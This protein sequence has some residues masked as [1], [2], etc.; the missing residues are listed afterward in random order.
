MPA[1]TP[2][3]EA[4]L[5]GL[6]GRGA[7][8][9]Q[10]TRE[11]FETLLG[12]PLGDVRLHSDARAGAL[13]ASLNANALAYGRD[14][15]FAPG[16]LQ[17]DS[18]S[19]RRLLAH[20]ITHV[21][22][23]DTSG[24]GAG[25]IH[26]DTTP[27]A[28]TTTDPVPDVGSAATKPKQ[29][30]KSD[31]DRTSPT[32]QKP[33]GVAPQRAV[34]AERLRGHIAAVNEVASAAT[35]ASAELRHTTT[36]GLASVDGIAETF[37]ETAENY[38]KAHDS[39]KR[40]LERA[41]QDAADA[42][43]MFDAILG[44][45]IGVA[46]AFYIVPLIEAVATRKLLVETGGELA[47]LGISKALD[48]AGDLMREDGSAPDLLSPEAKRLK[49]SREVIALYRRL[50]ALQTGPDVAFIAVVCKDVIIEIERYD[51]RRNRLSAQKIEGLVAALRPKEAQ[52]TDLKMKARQALTQI[53]ARLHEARAK[54]AVNGPRQL[55]EDI[56]TYWLANGGGLSSE[57]VLKELRDLGIIG[58][59]A[60]FA[61]LGYRS[62]SHNVRE[63]ATMAVTVR[64]MRGKT[65]IAKTRLVPADNDDVKTRLAPAGSVEVGGQVFAAASEGGP[66]PAGAAVR[67]S[68]IFRPTEYAAGHQE[69]H[70]QTAVALTV[71]AET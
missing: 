12:R 28:A 45:A 48:A 62:L 15:I 70:T 27:A 50:V 37:S 13:A 35:A 17:P 67:V 71:V 31:H 36:I 61:D 56:W 10:T 34:T 44:V 54:L 18:T 7:P 41:K 4:A 11:R 23:N 40:V 5:G 58:A 46:A 65:G 42:A 14:I 51:D 52:A 22:Q 57:I 66:I 47:E 39:H 68:G 9:P 60:E 21:V 33:A 26:R 1:V 64:A 30:A 20:E 3:H 16:K 2:A 29:E 38:R 63:D 43:A 19:G 8:L 6:R 55:L 53:S 25:V 32:S 24:G 69:F 59:D 49:Q